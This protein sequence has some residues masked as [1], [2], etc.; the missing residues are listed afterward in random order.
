MHESERWYVLIF[1]FSTFLIGYPEELQ[2]NFEA[3]W[4]FR[5]E[6]YSIE[7]NRTANDPALEIAFEAL[8][9]KVKIN[10]MLPRKF[11]FR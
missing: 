6:V 7:E 10:L 5:S 1:I 8:V 4:F 9:E 2:K 11:I 3:I